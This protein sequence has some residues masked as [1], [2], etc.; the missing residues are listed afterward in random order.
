MLQ[1][2]AVSQLPEGVIFQQDGTP[3]YY[4]N[5]VRELL[6]T[7]FPPTVDRHGYVP[8][9][10][11]TRHSVIDFTPAVRALLEWLWGKAS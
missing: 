7:T 6:D 11:Q 2:Y 1:L 8:K 9:E 10:I 5:I 4:G 3:P